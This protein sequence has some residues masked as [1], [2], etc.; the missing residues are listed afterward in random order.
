M[1]GTIGFSYIGF[2]FLCSLII[3]N[4]FLWA[5]VKK[6]RKCNFKLLFNISH[7]DNNHAEA[8]RQVSRLE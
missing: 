1:F 7:E 6:S 5:A 4:I 3:P 8:R 2:I